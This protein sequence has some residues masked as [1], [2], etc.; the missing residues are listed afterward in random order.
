MEILIPAMIIGLIP[1]FIA[2]SKGRQFFLWWIYGTLIF[3]VA[4]IHSLIIN[5]G[6]VKKCPHCAE[7]VKREATVCRYCGKEL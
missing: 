7:T 2:K 1:A 6:D 3:I 4:L 5:A